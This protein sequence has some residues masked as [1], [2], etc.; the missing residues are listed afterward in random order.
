[1]QAP[2][3]PIDEGSRLQTLHALHLL[4][5]PAEERFD[6]LTRLAVRFFGVPIAAVALVDETRQWFK[7][8]HGLDLPQTARSVSFCGWT[9]NERATLVVEDATKDAR[10]ADNPLVIEDPRFRFYAGHPIFAA[11]DSA[12]GTFAIFDYVP[13]RVG[14]PDAIALRDFA[15]LAENEVRSQKLTTAQLRAMTERAAVAQDRIDPLTRLW[16]RPAVL[17]L[18][19][20]EVS[21]ASETSTSVGVLL[22]DIDAFRGV[23]ERLGATGGD[24]ALCEIVKR[25]RASVRPYDS[26]GRYGGEKFLVLLPG[27]DEGTAYAAAERI[28]LSVAADTASPH[29]PVTVS[30]GVAAVDG[31]SAGSGE[32]IVRSAEVALQ[33]AKSNGRN[34]VEI[35]RD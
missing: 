15:S 29:A 12:I 16:N 30:I 9:I 10:F 23:N 24:A 13:R 20:H 8:I 18:L 31:P 3:K 1:M 17:R 34:R 26:V 27:T 35:A 14:D 33:S 5:T 4:D 19:E 11:D 7:S 2:P 21:H 22:V 32:R 6:R 28:R 25:I